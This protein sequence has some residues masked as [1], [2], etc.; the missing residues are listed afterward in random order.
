MYFLKLHMH[1][2]RTKFQNSCLIPP[3]RTAKRARKKPTLYR[4]IHS[5]TPV[6]ESIFNKVG[7]LKALNFIK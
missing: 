7:G 3:S 1:V 6:L 2:L 5:R 4:N